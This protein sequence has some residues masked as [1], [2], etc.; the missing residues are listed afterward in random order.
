VVLDAVDARVGRPA[1]PASA[2]GVIGR[3]TRRCAAGVA[4]K[5]Q[6]PEL[7]DPVSTPQCGRIGL[8]DFVQQ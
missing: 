5:P 3:A 8:S 2:A 6:W 4:T 1:P 7:F